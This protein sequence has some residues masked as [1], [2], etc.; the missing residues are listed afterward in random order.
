M[1]LLRHAGFQVS[2]PLIADRLLGACWFAARSVCL[3]HPS[4]C[5]FVVVAGIRCIALSSRCQWRTVRRCMVLTLDDER[6]LDEDDILL[7]TD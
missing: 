7:V 3:A 2:L 1:F 4:L 5:D 6:R